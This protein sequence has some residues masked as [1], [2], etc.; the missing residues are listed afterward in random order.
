MS[1]GSLSRI[2]GAA[3]LAMPLALISEGSFAENPEREKC[4]CDIERESEPNNGAW[5]KNATA[6]WSTEDR[7]RQWCDITVQSLEG[8]GPHSAIVATL[9][10]YESDGPAL[11]G[12]FT[13]QF[14]QF[15]AMYSPSEDKPFDA[16]Q[17]RQVV[18]SLLKENEVQIVECVQG[19]RDGKRGLQVEG[20]ETLRCNIGE[21]SGWLR[22]AFRVGEL[23]LV[24]MLAPDV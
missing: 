5:V 18:P 2:I 8:G 23:W 15:I 3:V 12:V 19:F 7:A 24:Y 22:I 10:K 13:D 11:V 9:Y 20:G 16:E 1:E 14:E 4:T 6:C 21:S 17:A